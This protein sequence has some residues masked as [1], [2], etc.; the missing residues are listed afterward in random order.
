MA[1]RRPLWRCDNPTVVQ[2][3]SMD[4]HEQHGRVCLVAHLAATGGGGG[5]GV[6]ERLDRYVSPQCTRHELPFIA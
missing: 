5:G 4:R 1:L 2:Q 6:P 3:Q